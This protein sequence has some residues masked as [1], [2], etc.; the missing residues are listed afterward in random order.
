MQPK[1]EELNHLHVQAKITEW[2]LLFYIKIALMARNKEI[3]GA[4]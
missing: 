4:H 1:L 2:L 3:L